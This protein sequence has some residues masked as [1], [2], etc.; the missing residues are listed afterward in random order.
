[1]SFT[2]RQ[3]ISVSD[4]EKAALWQIAVVHVLVSKRQ[5]QQSNFIYWKDNLSQGLLILF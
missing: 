3:Q 1:M 2:F 5:G 4:V